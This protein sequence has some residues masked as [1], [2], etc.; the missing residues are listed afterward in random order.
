MTPDGV[1]TTVHTF[2]QDETE[3]GPLVQ[4]LDGRF[5]GTGSG[6]FGRGGVFRLSDAAPPVSTAVVTPLPNGA[7]WNNTNV[8]VQL[9][10]TDVGSGVQRLVYAAIG[11]QAIAATIVNG[12]SAAIP[13]T[14]EGTTTLT[15]FAVDN[16]GNSETPHTVTVKIDK[17]PP[18]VTCSATP[19]VLWPPNQQM[20]NV[21][22]SVTVTDALSGSAG[23]DLLGVTSSEPNSSQ[24]IAGWSVG[25]PDTAGLLRASRAP[26]GPG[27][28]YALSYQAT[29]QAG[30]SA[31]C[32][33]TVVVPH[34]QS[35][36]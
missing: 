3:S 17:T 1:F 16:A 31:G 15:F 8:T 5:Y 22:T 32:V 26:A 30:N 18:T 7:G 27:R 9:T 35:R 25:G 2:A 36:P 29:D 10:A 13:L 24:D 6:A 4:A 33:T 12:S 28:I 34:D 19:N 23:Y 14:A 21:S 20:V 11:A